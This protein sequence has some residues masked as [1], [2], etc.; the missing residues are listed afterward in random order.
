MTT[1]LAPRFSPHGGAHIG[2]GTAETMTAPDPMAEAVRYA[3][4]LSRLTL[5]TI[6]GE[7]G[8]KRDT[9][10]AYRRGLR[11]MPAPARRALAS[12]LTRHAAEVAA[13][14][15]ALLEEGADSS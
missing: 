2:A 8:I 13:A 4:D 15:A 11:R 12:L 3:L 5:P 7:L 14:A 1:T 6:G 10:E 9:L